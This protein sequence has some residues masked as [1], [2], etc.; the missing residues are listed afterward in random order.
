MMKALFMGLTLVGLSACMSGDGDDDGT[1][2]VCGNLVCE[3]GES[4]L[5]CAS[6]CAIAACDPA[7]PA[8]CGGETICINQQCVP[9]FG[10]N[11]VFTVRSGTFPQFDQMGDPWD[12]AGGLPDG[13]VRLTINGAPF[14]TPA[15]QDNLTPTWNFSTPPT[16]IP[17][18]TVLLIEVFDEDL[19]ADDGAWACQA[20]PLQASMLRGRGVTCAGTGLPGSNINIDIRP[21]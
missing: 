7:T 9:A 5:T 14:T 19:A 11:Y 8:S 17:G 1:S 6:D 15:V 10:R 12:A 4:S 21:N 16:L 20:N 13:F 2:P 3:A 18:G